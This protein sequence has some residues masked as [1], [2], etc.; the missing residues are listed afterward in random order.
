MT[1][2]P[3]IFNESSSSSKANAN[4]V[5]SGRFG[6]SSFYGMDINGNYVNQDLGEST[7]K[8]KDIYLSGVAN[9]ANIK[10]DGNTIESTD[11]DG[12]INLVPDGDGDTNIKNP[13]LDGILFSDYSSETTLTTFTTTNSFSS[14]SNTAQAT[15]D[16]MI[17]GYIECR[18]GSCEARLEL[19]S[20]S[21]ANP[22]TFITGFKTLDKTTK[23][24]LVG[25][26]RPF[27]FFCKK[28]D[29]YKIY[30]YL[31]GNSISYLDCKYRIIGIG[32]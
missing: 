15:T 18:T 8:W 25:E 3:I 14:N 20:D 10:I 2:N 22:T 9:I 6:F 12:D 1:Y 11:T 27:T 31:N 28:N 4:W 29:Y 26:R 16:L 32:I 17:V 13:K 7:K 23:P 24:L 5:H 30:L 19:Y 21:N